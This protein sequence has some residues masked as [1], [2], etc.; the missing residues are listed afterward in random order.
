MLLDGLARG[1]PRLALGSK[2]A[3]NVA[4]FGSALGDTS[5]SGASP[6]PAVPQHLQLGHGEA[7]VAAGSSGVVAAASGAGAGAGAGTTGT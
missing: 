7:A 5:A 6:L 4:M 2:S 3:R 1:Q